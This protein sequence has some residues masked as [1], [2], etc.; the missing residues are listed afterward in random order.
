[1]RTKLLA[2][3]VMLAAVLAIVLSAPAA[4]QPRISNC[5]PIYAEMHTTWLPKEGVEIGWV[6]GTIEGGAYF[7]YDDEAPPLEPPFGKPNLVL[8][9][10]EGTI[11]LWVSGESTRDGGVI[12]RQLQSLQAIGSDTYAKMRIV[13]TVEGI[14]VP[15]KASGSYLLQGWI[16]TPRLKPAG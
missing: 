6:A 8:S 3:H 7:T 13:L 10:K 4:A 11:E 1:M 9:M 16:C 12:V 15:E 14:L 2:A 5:K